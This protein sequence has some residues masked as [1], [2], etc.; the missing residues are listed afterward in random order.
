MNTIESLKG[1]DFDMKAL[2]KSERGRGLFS[3]SNEVST[4]I[5][6]KPSSTAKKDMVGFE[7]TYKALDRLS[8]Y[9]WDHYS[10]LPGTGAYMEE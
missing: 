6:P 1:W 8:I 9:K 3:S 5:F 4:R 10:G 7:G 2:R